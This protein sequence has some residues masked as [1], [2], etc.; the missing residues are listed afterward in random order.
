MS[1]ERK[2]GGRKVRKIESS[3]TKEAQTESTRL[4]TENSP[5]TTKMEVHHHPQLE[6]K[7]KPWKEY[8][9]EYLMIFLAVMT[10]FFAESYREH[11]GDKNREKEYMISMVED[12]K[13]DTAMA[14]KM[15]SYAKVTM[16]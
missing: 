4:T 11:I 15:I 14:V 10:G 8:L 13:S 9:L 3:K 7:P 6:H 5:L 12:L 16:P 2:S 1:E